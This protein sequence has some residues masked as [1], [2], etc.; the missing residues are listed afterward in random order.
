MQE[1]G[2]ITFFIAVWFLIPYVGGMFLFNRLKRKWKWLN[3]KN[4]A[5]KVGAYGVFLLCALIV[6]LI[7]D[8]I[9]TGIKTIL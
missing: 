4:F 9:L 8:L 2:Y 5:L 6:W 3:G 7:E 1:L